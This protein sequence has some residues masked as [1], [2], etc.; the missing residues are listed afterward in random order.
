M[1]NRLTEAEVLVEDKLFATLDPTTRKI[2]LPNNQKILFTDTVGFVRKLPHSLVEAFKS[3]LEETVVAEFLLHIVDVSNPNAEAHIVTTREV[4]T[5]IGGGE[6]FEIIVFNKLDRLEDPHA[7]RRLR[8]NHPKAV[9]ISAKTGEGI[10][11]LVKRITEVIEDE[12][13]PL[14][15]RI[16]HDRYDVVAGLHRTAEIHTENFE[17]D[18]I[19]LEVS[20]PPKMMGPLAP[21]VI[22]A[23]PS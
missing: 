17:E 10:D 19:Y 13:S 18:A 12:L 1:L 9:F 20:V 11:E 7:I 4:L 14:V 16:P 2:L 5:E 8:R 23:L 6:H 22:D 3:T 21:F 15:L